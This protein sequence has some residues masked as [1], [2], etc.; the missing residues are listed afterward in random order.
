M[1]NFLARAAARCWGLRDMTL[2]RL[3]A[4]SA[5]LR[6]VLV[7]LFCAVLFSPAAHADAG[8][9]IVLTNG[10]TYRARLRLNFLQCLASE[11]RI[12]RKFGDGG[13]AGV[14][15]FMSSRELPSDWPQ[16]FRSK[17]G[18]CERYAEGVWAKPTMPR[19]RP[20][21]IDAWWVAL[22]AAA[23]GEPVASR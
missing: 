6:F 1:R 5:I 2:L 17:A 13:F 23:R 12:A 14:R 21:S 22:L 15:V 20:S 18:S 9:D 19:R 10:V 11:D 8:G 3:S 16:Q 7:P 4:S